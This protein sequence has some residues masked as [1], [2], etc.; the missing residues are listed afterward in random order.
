MQAEIALHLLPRRP[1]QAQAA[2]TAISRTSKQ[3]LDELRATL[4]AV[5]H[6]DDRAPR[7]GLAQLPALRDRLAHAGLPVTVSVRDTPAAASLPR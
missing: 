3:G 1:E 2:L 5:R 4:A 6:G 7:P